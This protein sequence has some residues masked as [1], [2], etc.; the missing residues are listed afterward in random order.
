MVIEDPESAQVYARGLLLGELVRLRPLDERDLTHLE[1]WWTDPEWQVLQQAV[2][3]PRPD[4]PTQDLFRRWSTNEDGSGVGF[5]V[6]SLESGEFIGHVTLWGADPVQRA[7][8]LGLIIGP[9]FVGRG[10]GTD[11]VRVIARYGFL[12]MHLHRI[13]LEVFAFNTRGRRAYESAGF[14]VEGVRRESVFLAGGWADSV[15]MGLLRQ[16][17][18]AA[19]DGRRA[20]DDPA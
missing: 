12:A 8:T 16:D 19:E 20:P 15:L 14:Q 1:R 11:T 10:F 13:G 17:W 4:G 9:A 3:R 5:S 7:A 6:E 2:V 18:E